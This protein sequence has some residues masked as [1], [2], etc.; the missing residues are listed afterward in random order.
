MATLSTYNTQIS[1]GGSDIAGVTDISGP[2]ESLTML[3]STNLQ[4]SVMTRI[5]GLVDSGEVNLTI[6][7]DPDDTE[8]ALL[9]TRLT[10]RTSDTFVISWP[11]TSPT[12]FTFTAFVSS[13]QPSAGTNDKLTASV[14]LTIT[15]S[16]ATA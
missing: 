12:T 11:D 14:T 1:I 10:G 7:Y 4:S 16:I 8:H 13:F 3:D 9:R 6:D 5:A 2:N 15:G